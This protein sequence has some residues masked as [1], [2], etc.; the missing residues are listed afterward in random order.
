MLFPNLETKR[1]AL[2]E[3]SKT[4]ISQL[5]TIFSDIEAMRFYGQ[6]VF[7]DLHEA[8]ALLAFFTKSFEEKRGLRWGIELKQQR[9]LIGTVGF[10]MWSPKHKRAEI[11][12]EIHPDHWKKGYASEAVAEILSYGFESMELKRVGA[13]VFTENEA[14]S[15]LLLEKGFSKEG[16]LRDYMYQG[17]QSHDTNVYSLLKSE[18]LSNQ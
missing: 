11:G 7:T 13:V 18:F 2:R 9:V 8:E 14:S 5:F 1:L 3:L 6:E 16:V 12:Y 4:D 10:N 15:K 17:G